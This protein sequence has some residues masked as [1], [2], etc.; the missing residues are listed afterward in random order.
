M[1][2]STDQGSI[3]HGAFQDSTIGLLAC[4]STADLSTV[5]CV[6]AY[7]AAPSSTKAS[8]LRVTAGRT[9]TFVAT[10]TAEAVSAASSGSAD[11][12]V[13]I[14][15]NVPGLGPV[16]LDASSQ[17]PAVSATSDATCLGH[18]LQYG[19]TA[20]GP[21]IFGADF[22]EGSVNGTAVRAWSAC[23]AY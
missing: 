6:V 18:P 2:G 22:V 4:V 15:F 3:P 10:G 20:T 8:V 11:P 5:Y 1:A 7:Q 21:S 12:D 23:G 16:I 9:D 14:D 19:L 17:E 13:H